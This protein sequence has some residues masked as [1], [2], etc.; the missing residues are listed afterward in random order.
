MLEHHP[1]GS[2]QFPRHRPDRNNAIGSGFLSIIKSLRQ[3]LKAYR[4]MRRLRE[5]PGE[6]LITRLGIS[7]TF[8]LSIAHARAVD[9]ATVRS[10]IT[11]T[12]K[13]FDW[14]GFQHDSE[15]EYFPNTGDRL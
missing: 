4:K 6:I 2:C 9:T 10:K 3:W 11:R 14:A 5:S 1:G 12:R 15:A 8:L 13:T 7:H